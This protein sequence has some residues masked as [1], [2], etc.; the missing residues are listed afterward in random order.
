MPGLGCA[1]H[2]FRHWR[3]ALGLVLFGVAAGCR[4]LPTP[5]PLLD[6][7]VV[8]SPAL[9]PPDRERAA[10]AFALYSLGIHHELADD[11]A[12]A[13]DAYRRAAAKGQLR[14]P[15]DPEML[16]YDTFLFVGGLIKRWISS[17]PD[18]RFRADAERFITQHV[19]LRRA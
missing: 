5:P 3:L 15:V 14:L 19:A 9:L 11:Y 2:G 16:A 17:T 12:A 7:G 18:E 10:Q 4:S 6:G 13:Y 8:S 1:M